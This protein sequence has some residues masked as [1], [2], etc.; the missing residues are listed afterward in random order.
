MYYVAADISGRAELLKSTDGI[1]WQFV[2][3]ISD[4]YNTT[5]TSLVF[6][7]D[8]RLLALSRQNKSPGSHWPG[9]SISSPPYTS[10]DYTLGNE[11]YFGGPA[12][13]LIGDTIVVASRTY[14]GNWGLPQEP[15]RENQR[16]ALYRFNL[17]TMRLELQAM[18]P[19]KQGGDSSY[20]GILRLGND[21]AIMC[22]YDGAIDCENPNPSEIWL[23][24]I[25][26]V[27][28]D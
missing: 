12:A 19:S 20:P 22:W 1:N 8:N 16:T 4:R 10:W 21:R 2:S 7:P 25:K 27:D 11:A 15:P 18:L 28:A 14:L 5:E 3:V 26:I 13:E 6:L 17:K 9:F 23:A 24:H